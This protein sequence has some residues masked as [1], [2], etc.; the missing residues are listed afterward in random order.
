MSHNTIKGVWK[1]EIEKELSKIYRET[2]AR[3]ED[4]WGVDYYERIETKNP[5]IMEEIGRLEND[6]NSLW[7]GI[8]QGN[9]SI[10]DFKKALKEWEILHLRI[11]NIMAFEPVGNPWITGEGTRNA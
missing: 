3:F 9:S 1:I 4:R 5:K 10:E 2:T 11:I 8:R 7:V 6:L